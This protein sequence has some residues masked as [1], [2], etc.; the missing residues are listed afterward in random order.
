MNIKTDSHTPLNAL[1]NPDVN[2]TKPTEGLFCEKSRRK[3]APFLLLP[4]VKMFSEM[5][6]KKLS[7]EFITSLFIQICL[8]FHQH[9]CT[10]ILKTVSHDWLFKTTKLF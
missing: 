2:G 9:F 8:I 10:V 7:Y 5:D 1:Q 4:E 3:P 6:S